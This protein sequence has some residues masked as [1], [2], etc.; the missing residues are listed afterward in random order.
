M[1]K[2]MDNIFTKYCD[3]LAHAFGCAYLVLTFQMFIEVFIACW[4]VVVLSI[5]KELIDEYILKSKMD[6][7][8]L[9]ADCIGIIIALIPLFIINLINL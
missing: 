9:I 5:V 1:M 3:K 4:I 7:K 6:Y 8:D 2:Q